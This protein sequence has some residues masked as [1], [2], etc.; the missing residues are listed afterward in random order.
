MKGSVL[1]NGRTYDIRHFPF[2][3]L[4]QETVQA[5]RALGWKG[6]GLFF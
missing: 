3:N 5:I 1:S 4:K 6:K 2:Q